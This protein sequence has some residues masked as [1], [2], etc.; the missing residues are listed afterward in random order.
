MQGAVVLPQV[1]LGLVPGPPVEQGQVVLARGVGFILEEETTRSGSLNEMVAITLAIVYFFSNLKSVLTSSRPGRGVPSR[2]DAEPR[3]RPCPGV[4][5]DGL[6][7]W[8][9]RQSL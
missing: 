8:P 6:A 9:L 2:A 7:P 4:R 1:P 3:A 5:C